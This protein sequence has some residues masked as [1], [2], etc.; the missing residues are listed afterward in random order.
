MTS[1]VTEIKSSSLHKQII[2][3][4]RWLVRPHPNLSAVDA[5]NATILMIFL[6]GYFT[7]SLIGFMFS[8]S[9]VMVITSLVSL[10]LYHWLED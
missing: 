9:L 1:Q 8:P 10:I 7:T 6:L 2:S 3:V 5:S 4:L